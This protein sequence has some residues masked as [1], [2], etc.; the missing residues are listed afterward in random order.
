MIT[1]NLER[2]N[3]NFSVTDKLKEYAQNPVWQE[4]YS[5]L[6]EFVS[7]ATDGI[8]KVI[9]EHIANFVQNIRDIDTCGL[10]QLYS[11]A[12]ELNVEQLFSYDLNYPGD[13]GE[14][15]DNLSINKSYLL[16]S[17]Y[18]LTN[19]N[20]KSIYTNLGINISS[21][22]YIYDQTYISGFLEPIISANLIQNSLYTSNSVYS[23]L[24]LDYQGFM[25]DI[26]S[27][28]NIVWSETTSG[29]IIEECTHTLRNVAIRA[30]YQRETL[31]KI[32]QKHAMIG[33]TNSIEKIIGE[34]ILRSFTKKDDWR[35]YTI[36]SGATK[37]IE[38]NNAYT[39]EQSL[40]KITDIN[41]YFGVDVVE[42]WDNTEYLNI[43]AMSPLVCGL[44]GYTTGYMVTSNVD[45]SGNYNTGNILT[46]FPQYGTGL[47][48][49]VVTGGNARF[50]EGDY[51]RDSIDVSDIT[52][53]M[54]SAYYSHIGLT[55]SLQDNWN[56]NVA[57]W[58]NYAVSGF[59]RNAVIPD[60]TG[61]YSAQY[62]ATPISAIPDSGWLVKPTSL[63]AIH[64]KY[65]GNIS[66]DTPQNNYKNQLYPTIAIQ[67]FIWNLV[68]KVYEDF[69]DIIFS[70]LPSQI[71]VEDNLSGRIDPSGNL[72]DSWRY[73]NH[74]YIG[75]QTYYEQSSNLDFNDKENPNID[76]DGSF[77]M[78][79]LSAY[80][81]N[82]DMTEFYTHILKNF[83]LSGSVP[84]ITTQLTAFRNDILSLSGQYVYQYAFDQNDHHYMLYKDQR[85]LNTFGTLWMRYRN[86][87]L[88][89]PL[90][91]GTN[92]DYMLQQLYVR[93]GMG[94]DLD[95]A[96]NGH[97]Y[98]FGFI[99][100]I[101]WLLGQ[102]RNGDDI[103]YVLHNDY[104]IFPYPIDKELYSVVVK[105]NDIPLILNIGSINNFIGYYSYNSYI[106]FVYI[107]DWSTIDIYGKQSVNLKF[108]HYN[109]Y[110][111]QFETTS[112]ENVT[113]GNLPPQYTPVDN[114]NVWR[115]AVSEKL[116][117]LAYESVNSSGGEY[118][119]NITTIDIEKNILN[120][121]EAL[122]WTW[123]N[124]LDFD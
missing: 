103:V 19:E 114:S 11:L 3:G 42:Y 74:E 13:L 123:E 69:P 37:S 80:I 120:G 29:M 78:D 2:I 41:T 121:S 107:V 36:P 12:K 1:G 108:K 97:C 73:Y 31:K 51:L 118:I 62:S 98:D 27:D 21:Q 56:F 8:G 6:W 122:V 38:I 58:S 105:G 116:V 117:S 32:A 89:F 92:T 55:G 5:S 71:L 52:S 94:I 15:M 17:G 7:G 9:Y 100:D 22:L 23:G 67:P 28:P 99:G 25:D 16:T 47:C 115:M 46:S 87:P 82:K 85:S 43:S 84:T 112:L 119:N 64:Y 45:V 104:I 96:I 76:R 65:I 40:P 26:Y 61:T 110:T 53:G 60:L 63:S 93:G 91:Y 57:L 49:Y 113:I 79:A 30:S 14:I 18:I 101:M 44:I 109:K 59:D 83:K 20:L 33:T 86:H 4:E 34:Y 39:M 124:I 66:G 54:L 10:H 75:Y 70:L 48:G 24:A 68:E 81:D 50:W 72:I 95:Y 35:L 102:N 77:H 106:I 111:K 88:P 90:S